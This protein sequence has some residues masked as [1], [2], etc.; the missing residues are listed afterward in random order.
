MNVAQNSNL[1]S[2]DDVKG[3]ANCAGTFDSCNNTIGA[4]HDVR[5]GEASER[6]KHQIN[7]TKNPSHAAYHGVLG[8][9][10][11]PG[12]M[13][14]RSH[15]WAAAARDTTRSCQI[16]A[17]VGAHLIHITQKRRLLIDNT[18]SPRPIVRNDATDMH[19]ALDE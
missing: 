10:M 3:L 2:V 5:K 11:N 15:E 13:I 18:L 14:V 4:I 9:Q 19:E 6:T 16:L 17:I 8:P 7:T 12:R 1:I